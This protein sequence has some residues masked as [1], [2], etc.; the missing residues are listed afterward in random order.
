MARDIRD[1][2][3]EK[4]E[5]TAAWKRRQATLRPEDQRAARSAEAL[6]HLAEYV[7][8]LDPGDERLLL[9]ELANGTEDVFGAGG[10]RSLTLLY[11]F[12]FDRPARRWPD[13]FDRF[14]DHF[15]QEVWRDEFERVADTG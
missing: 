5:S 13:D 9:L 10:R 11:R 15:V 14:I 7:R 3:A 12:G 4:V 2:F 1:L 8:K 6:N